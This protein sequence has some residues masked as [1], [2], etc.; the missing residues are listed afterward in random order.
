MTIEV[1][2][3]NDSEV[4]GW[5]NS[6]HTGF[7]MHTADGEAD[8]RRGDMDLDRTW[9]AVDQGQIVG[10]LRS[11]PTTLTVP[12][13]GGIKA[14]ALTNV[15]VAPTHR[16]RGSLTRMIT[17]DLTASAG[18]GEAVGIL[19]ASEYPIY[20]R[21][22]YGPAAEGAGYTVDAS[23][24]SFRRP[25]VGTVGLVDLATLRKEAPPLYEQ[26]R[27]S[28]PGSIERSDRWWDRT[29]QQVLVPGADPQK[30]YQAIFRSDDG[31]PEGYVRYSAKEEWDQMRPKGLLTVHELVA[32]SPAA[33]QRLWRYCCEI[34]LVT[35]VEA[36]D[37]CVDEPLMWLLNDARTVRQTARFDF[38]WLRVLDVCAAL[39]SRRYSA[40]GRVII[41][42][43]DPMGLAAG[44]YA[45]DGG[46]AGAVCTRTDEPAELGLPVDALGAIFLGGVS[47]RILAAAGRVDEHSSGALATADAMFRSGVTPWCSTWF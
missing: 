21:F 29:L 27:M 45:L 35:S 3:I 26:F 47:V 44:R 23:Q 12:G 25:G 11:V 8:Y 33:Y 14:A 37:R 18:R 9:A 32:T 28:R 16:R 19:I 22:G 24:A 30:G 5:V 13:P 7:L 40:S 6:M 20:G 1:R 10:T 17:N 4:E 38:L 39:A 46:P 15:T 36:S 2:T 34:D 42:V 43:I 31:Q 41:D